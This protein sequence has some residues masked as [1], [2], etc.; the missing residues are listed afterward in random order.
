MA[1]RWNRAATTGANGKAKIKKNRNGNATGTKIAANTENAPPHRPVTAN[2]GTAT[3]GTHCLEGERGGMG[4]T[5]RPMGG[6]GNGEN[7]IWR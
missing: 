3:G 6:E 2:R 7:W 1:G 4:T 5:D